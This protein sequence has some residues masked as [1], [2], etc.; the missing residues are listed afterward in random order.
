MPAS[1][2][3]SVTVSEIV[4]LA[5]PAGASVLAGQTGL[6]RPITW[7]RLLTARPSGVVEEG[8]LLLLPADVL[9]SS[10]APRT[11]ARLIG[12]LVEAGVRAF[13]VA[14]A[15]DSGVREVCASTDTPLILVPPGSALA[16]L[17]RAV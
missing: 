7:S 10:G 6:E 14:E 9:T 13:V 2:N 4:R 3:P 1:S 12:Q 8:E 5:L 16:E 11:P 17:E 15:P